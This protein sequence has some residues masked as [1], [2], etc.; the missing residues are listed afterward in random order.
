MKKRAMYFLMLCALATVSSAFAA[1][2]PS[3]TN[4]EIYSDTAQIKK[5]QFRREYKDK[6]DELEK[7]IE[8]TRLE[9]KKKKKE[10]QVQLNKKLDDL[11][12]SRK[13]LAAKLQTSEEKSA[14]NWDKFAKEVREEYDETESKVR[15]FFKK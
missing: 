3:T 6:V 14:E 8:V 7:H 10:S 9:I 15:N 1:T 5:E 4:S 12:E 2:I 13:S 11:E